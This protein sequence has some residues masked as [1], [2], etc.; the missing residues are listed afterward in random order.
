MAKKKKIPTLPRGMGAFDELGS[1]LLRYRKYV[2]DRNGNRKRLQVTGPTAEECFALMARKEKGLNRDDSKEILKDALM[3]YLKTYTKSGV[4]EQSYDRVLKTAEYI[5][6]PLRSDLGYLRYQ[7]ISSDDIMAHL[8]RLNNDGKSYSE[9]K[10]H[11]YLLK[12]FFDYSSARHDFKN[13]IDLVK[14][15][16]KKNI[17]TPTKEIR[18][19]DME[20][21]QRFQDRALKKNK[22]GE[23]LY[24]YG[25]VIAA[26]MYMGLRIGEL[27]A[28]NWDDID[29][30]KRRLRVTKTIVGSSRNKLQEYTKTEKNRVIPINKKAYDLLQLQR[31]QL[32]PDSKFPAIMRTAGNKRPYEKQIWENIH[33]IKKW[34]RTKEQEG[35]THILRLTC[36]RNG[37]TNWRECT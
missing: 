22:N 10:K 25:P 33:Q 6:D 32:P 19:F 18:F 16:A 14:L 36:A 30:E 7:T 34:G 4:K 15:P 23:P 11:Y 17:K 21:R 12:A 13:P 9:I 24:K 31:N 8:N 35:G 3:N 26:N 1:G 29:F 28:L 5:S 37:S 27:I 2:K 20:D